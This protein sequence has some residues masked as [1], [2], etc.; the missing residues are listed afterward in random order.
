MRDFAR[1]KQFFLEPLNE[2]GPRGDFRMELL[3]RDDFARFAVPRR[4]ND[5]VSPSAD[6][7]EQFETHGDATFLS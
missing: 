2:F 4:V 3:E 5:A 6:F 7:G 1:Q